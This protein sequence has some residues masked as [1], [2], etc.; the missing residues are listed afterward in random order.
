MSE[1]GFIEPKEDSKGRFYFKIDIDGKYVKFAQ[2]GELP[3][4]FLDETEAYVFTTINDN[5]E[6]HIINDY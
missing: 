1:L 6:L 5:T 3:N 4:I 2:S